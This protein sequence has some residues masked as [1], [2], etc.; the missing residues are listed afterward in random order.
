[1]QYK[2]RIEFFIS[3]PSVSPFFAYIIFIIAFIS[4]LWWF[5]F[6]EF[7]IR[8]IRGQLAWELHWIRSNIVALIC[9]ARG[10]NF[11]LRIVKSLYV[12]SKNRGLGTSELVIRRQRVDPFNPCFLFLLSQ[13]WQGYTLFLIAR[14]LGTPFFTEFFQGFRQRCA[15]SRAHILNLLWNCLIYLRRFCPVVCRLSGFLVSG[16]GILTDGLFCFCKM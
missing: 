13:A 12:W 5:D 9:P 16:V 7:S 6:V 10:H 15:C 3:F 2:V 14:S 1:M 11:T 8:W 4:F